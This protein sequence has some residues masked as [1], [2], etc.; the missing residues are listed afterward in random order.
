[1]KKY[2][3]TIYSTS[4]DNYIKVLHSH[5]TNVYDSRI[6]EEKLFSRIHTVDRTLTFYIS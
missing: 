5:G 2:Y 6:I 4:P 3:N 1:M